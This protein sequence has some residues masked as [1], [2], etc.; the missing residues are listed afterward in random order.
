MRTLLLTL[1]AVSALSLGAVSAQATPTEAIFSGEA[2]AVTLVS[3]GCGPGAHRGE[4]GRCRSDG[5]FFRPHFERHCFIRRT[6]FGERR[7]C[8]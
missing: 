1:A 2:P 6:P 8:N 7:V 5:G 3:E 4:F